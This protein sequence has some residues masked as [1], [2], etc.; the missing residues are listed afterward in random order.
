MWT[1][2]KI[3]FQFS[4]EDDIS[5]SYQRIQ[6]LKTQGTDANDLLPL[7]VTNFIRRRVKILCGRKACP[8]SDVIPTMEQLSIFNLIYRNL[9]VPTGQ[10]EHYDGLMNEF[11]PRRMLDPI[12]FQ[13]RRRLSMDHLMSNQQILK[14]L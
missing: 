2:T 8:I 14:Q 13:R 1:N 6:Q 12:G 10:Q 11:V 5:E 3:C 9:F 7:A 4:I